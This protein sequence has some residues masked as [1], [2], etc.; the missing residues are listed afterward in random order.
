MFRVCLRSM[1]KGQRQDLNPGLSMPAPLPSGQGR[2]EGG[3][4][5]RKGQGSVWDKLEVGRWG[6][7][8]ASWKC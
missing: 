7:Q 4:L 2:A 6:M 5:E 1:A 3:K 8:D